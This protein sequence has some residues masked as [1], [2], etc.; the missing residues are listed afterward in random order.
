MPSVEVSE[1]IAGERSRVYGLISDMESYPRFMPSLNKLEVVEK[2]EGWTVTSWDTSISGMNFRWLER[3]EFDP[4]NGRITYRQVSG[5]LKRF[6]GEWRVEE[7]DG[8]CKVT[9]VVDFDFGVP[10]L[11]S[12]LN[13]V[14]TLK[15]R[16]NGEAMLRAIKSR[17]ETERK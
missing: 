9:L 12:L 3:D 16:Q 6:E 8:Q 5:D 1:L 4:G 2:G 17:C 13:P 14:A 7:A 10:M 15:L 11:S